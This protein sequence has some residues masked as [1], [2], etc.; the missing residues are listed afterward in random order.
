MHEA[1]RTELKVWE[2]GRVGKGMIFADDENRN[3]A[4]PKNLPQTVIRC[5]AKTSKGQCNLRAKTHLVCFKSGF[6]RSE[7]V[8]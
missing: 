8:Y 2:E 3:S 1:I 5:F 4:I 7:C 6:P